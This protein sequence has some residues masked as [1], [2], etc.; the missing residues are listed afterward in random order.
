MRRFWVVGAVIWLVFAPGFA[1]AADAADVIKN[2]SHQ[3]IGILN[4]TPQSSD[5]RKQKL[6]G[7]LRDSKYLDLPFVGR[8]VLGRHWRHL[9]SKASYRIVTSKLRSSA[10]LVHPPLCSAAIRRLFWRN[11]PSRW[12]AQPS[13]TLMTQ[14]SVALIR[15]WCAKHLRPSVTRSTGGSA[16]RATAGR[17]HRCLRSEGVSMALSRSARSLRPPYLQG[18][19]RHSDQSRLSTP[20]RDPGPPK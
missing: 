12:F 5:E 1:K 18:R 9:L 16:K 13:A 6:E 11:H 19:H 15:I 20:P 10:Y 17:V 2:L 7:L 8:F 4:G 3:A 14:D